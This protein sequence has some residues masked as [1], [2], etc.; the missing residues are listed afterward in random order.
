MAHVYRTSARYTHENT[1]RIHTYCGCL[2]HGA[3]ARPVHLSEE[4]A[5]TTA[6]IPG[7]HVTMRAVHAVHQGKA[8]QVV[9]LDPPSIR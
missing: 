8:S 6:S 2:S 4:H 7:R 3:G 1:K 9:H 5:C